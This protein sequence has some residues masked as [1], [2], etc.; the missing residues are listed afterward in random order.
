MI[1]FSNLNP[2]SFKDSRRLEDAFFSPQKKKKEKRKKK[3]L[4]VIGSVFLLGGIFILIIFL[5]NFSIVILPQYKN[6]SKEKE[7]NLIKNNGLSSITLLSPQLGSK[8]TKNIIFI[9]LPFNTHSGFAVNFKDKVNLYN[10]KIILVIKQISEPLKLSLI[11]R[12]NNFLSNA[13]KP[14]EITI[15]P[16]SHKTPYMEIPIE[17]EDTFEG[18]I[19]IRKVNQLR[20]IFHQKKNN[21][22]PLLIK[23]IVLKKRR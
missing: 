22:T 20:F 16:S 5:L 23:E 21:S 6:I 1:D 10:S 8:I 19:N 11:L 17:I 12:D 2:I 14:L 7:I 15:K 4:V 9:D 18:N 13:N 3:K